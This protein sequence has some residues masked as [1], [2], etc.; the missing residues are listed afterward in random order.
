LIQAEINRA[1]HSTGKRI[2]GITV[3]AMELL[4]RHD[5]PGNLDELESVVRRLVYLCPSGRPIDDSL[6][7]EDIRLAQVRVARPDAASELNLERLI[8]ACERGAIVE[9][10]RR[11]DGNKSEAARLLGLSRNGLAQKS[12]RLGLDRT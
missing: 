8:E 3:K 11:A 5:Y 1:C 12:L 6:L 10:L 7:P 9:A 4:A 2:Q